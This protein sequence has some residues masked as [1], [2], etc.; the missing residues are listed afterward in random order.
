MKKVVDILSPVGGKAGGVEEV[1]K[2]WTKNLNPDKFI[3]RVIHMSPGLA[4]L[5]G[6]SFA[7]SFPA[8]ER[9][10]DLKHYVDHYVEFVAKEGAPDICVATNW[11]LMCVAAKTVRDAIGGEFKIFSWVHNRIEP[12]HEAGLGGVAHLTYADA[13]LLLNSHNQRLILSENADAVCHLIGNPIDI[14][15]FEEVE[16]LPLQLVYVGRLADVKRVDLI[17][18]AMYRAKDTWRLRIVGDGEMR[19]E[20]EA[21]AEYLKISD[22]VEFL[23]W[24]DNP[25]EYVKDATA[26]VCTSEYEGFLL[27]G[28]EALSVGT[29]VISTPVD[30]IVD[31]IKPGVNGYLFSQENAVELAN[32]L[33]LLAAGELPV[34]SPKACR[35]SVEHYSTP[36][37]YKKL[38]E[39]FGD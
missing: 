31:V 29:Q 27:T 15:D 2:S 36:N 5:G 3:V 32:I 19:Q 6:Y 13:H 24:K 9:Q 11:P 35:E 4:Y 21:I 17:M 28:Y 30:G 10:D 7:Y 14:P 12:Y 23:G 1:I 33:D 37:Y 8:P 38:E 18:E 34:C 22:R 39:I 20:W 26:F 25:R 16:K